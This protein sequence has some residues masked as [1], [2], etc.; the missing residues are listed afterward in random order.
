M[1]KIHL[2]LCLSANILINTIFINTTTA[3]TTTVKP[4]ATA[5]A[6]DSVA[7]KGK[8]PAEKKGILKTAEYALEGSVNT[9]GWGLAFNTGFDVNYYTTSFWHF[10][11]AELKDTRE[12]LST[13]DR[14]RGIQAYPYIY[15][16]QNGLLLLQVGKG[17]KRQLSDKASERGVK[18]GYSYLY[19]IQCGL[20]KPY[21]LDILDRSPNGIN[22]TTRSIKYS[23]ETIN[24]FLNKDRIYGASPIF[25]GINETQLLPGAFGRIALNF[26]FLSDEEDYIWSVQTGLRTDAFIRDVPL[27]VDLPVLTDGNKFIHFNLFVALQFGKRH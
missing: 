18:V 8:V 14:T 4:T 23:P 17:R 5:A 10:G 19:G 12:T 24:D 13:S 1:K 16:K 22:Y 26:D 27:M 15:G 2:L 25:N 21:Y 9:G 3:Q 7:P 11:I 20:L 6:K